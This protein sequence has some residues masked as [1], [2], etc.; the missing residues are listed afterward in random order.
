PRALPRPERDQRRNFTA[1]P[2]SRPRSD[3]R[4][5]ATGARAAPGRPRKDR[6]MRAAEFIAAPQRPLKIAI[7]CPG[8]GLVQRGFERLFAD[9]FQ[10]VRDDFDVTLFKGAGPCSRNEK[11]LPFVSRTGKLVKIFPVHKL[12]GRTPYHSE[13]MTLA[14]AML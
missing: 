3:R 2:A 6:T 1:T 4:Q 12:F 9:Q 11:V 7:A 10:L 14:L 13:C 8:I 5:A